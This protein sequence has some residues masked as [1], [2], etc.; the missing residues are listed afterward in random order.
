M[1]QGSGPPILHVH[2]I[3]EWFYVMEGEMTVEVGRPDDYRARRRFLMDSTRHGAPIQGNEPRMPGAQ[4]LHAG[5]LRASDH[6]PRQ[7]GGAARVAAANGAAGSDYDRSRLA[8]THRKERALAG[9]LCRRASQWLPGDRADRD[10]RESPQRW[11]WAMLSL[12]RHSVPLVDN[13]QGRIAA[14]TGLRE[15]NEGSRKPAQVAGFIPEWR[16]VSNRNGGRLQIG[17]PGR[18]PRISHAR[19]G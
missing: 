1:R 4:R 10:C 18:L 13:R 7:A 15:A 19:R 6:R 14:V 3:D 2:P 11:L 17:I 16:P 5:G 12:R 8:G 9:P